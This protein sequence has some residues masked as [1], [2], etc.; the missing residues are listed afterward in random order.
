MTTTGALPASPRLAWGS[1]CGQTMSLPT[2]TELLLAWDAQRPR[3]QQAEMGMSK[4][5]SCRRQAGYHLGGYPHDEGYVGNKI[6]AVIG[7]AIPQ[8]AAEAA[9][10][11]VG[12]AIRAVTIASVSAVNL[13]HEP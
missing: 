12:Q 4:L 8:V 7:T 3:S 13:P 11:F 6:Q 2:T 5:G 9:R 10:E 1:S